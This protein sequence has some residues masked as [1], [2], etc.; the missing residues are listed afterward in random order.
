MSQRDCRFSRREVREVTRWSD[1]AL[2]VHIA[3]LVTRADL[4]VDLSVL[5]VRQGKGKK[6]RFVPVSERAMGWVLRY[7]AEARADFAI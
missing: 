5:A 4:H 3:R 1:T 7:V 6:E 2:K